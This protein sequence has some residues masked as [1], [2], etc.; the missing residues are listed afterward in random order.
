M[1]KTSGTSPRLG[2]KRGDASEHE[3]SRRVRGSL[4]FSLG[5]WG[6]WKGK[7]GSKIG[8]DSSRSKILQGFSQVLKFQC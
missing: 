4:L 2:S 6:S 3:A 8:I 7:N 5:S 1:D